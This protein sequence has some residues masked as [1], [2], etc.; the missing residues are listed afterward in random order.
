[1]RTQITKQMAE[2]IA[3]KLAATELH[4][5]EHDFQQVFHEGKLVATFGIRRGSKKDS[6]HDHIPNQLHCTTGFA[7]EIAKCTKWKKEYIEFLKEEG[8]I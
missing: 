4:K 5:T 1:M 2:I 6:G 8:F 3:V 7:K